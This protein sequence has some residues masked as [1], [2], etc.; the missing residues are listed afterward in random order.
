MGIDRYTQ[1]GQKYSRQWLLRQQSLSVML[2]TLWAAHR[3]HVND[4]GTGVLGWPFLDWGMGKLLMSV[5]E[6]EG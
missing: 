3:G 5:C 6:V 1:K 4:R 2:V